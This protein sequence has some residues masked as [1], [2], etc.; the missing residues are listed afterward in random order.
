MLLVCWWGAYGLAAHVLR[1][2]TDPGH[3]GFQKIVSITTNWKRG[4]ATSTHIQNVLEKKYGGRKVMTTEQ[5]T[6]LTVQQKGDIKT[7]LE[8]TFTGSLAI[9]EASKAY[10]LV[11]L[12]FDPYFHICLY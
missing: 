9:T 4:G 11:Q 12:G 1:C 6:A 3:E 10:S 5:T 8:K 7:Y 2:A